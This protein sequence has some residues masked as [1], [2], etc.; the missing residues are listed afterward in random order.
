[1]TASPANPPAL[2]FSPLERAF[3]RLFIV[4]AAVSWVGMVLSEAG[5][6]TLGR[7]LAGAGLATVAAWKL[8]ASEWRAEPASREPAARGSHLWLGV[9]LA[10][11]AVLYW[12]PGEYLIEGADAS[13]YLAVGH[14]IHRTGAIASADPVLQML[15][16]GGRDALLERERTWPHPLNRFPGGMRVAGGENVVA[17]DFFHLL[18]VWIAISIGIVG[19]YG[20]YY[21]NPVF[22]V[23]AVL[24][25]W[26]I[27]RRAWSAG[28]GSVAA[29]L[30]AV[31]FGQVCAARTA[32]SEMLAQWLL[33]SGVLFTILAR[34]RR[35][36]VAAACAGAAIGLAGF[37]R[38]DALFLLLPLG[39]AWL[40]MVRRRRL[41]GPAWLWY[42]AT[43]GAV[44]ANA[45]AHAFTVSRLYT[46]RLSA[47]AWDAA[48]HA[49]TALGPGTALAILG[50]VIA[51]MIVC[52][53]LLPTR[54]RILALSGLMI[55]APAAL[56]P[57]VVSTAT[58]LLTPVGVAAVMAG[59]FLILRRDTDAR[60]LPLLV[61]F[62]AEVILWLV[63]REKTSWPA[64]FR[65]FVPAV[66]P[67]GLLLVGGL[68][69]HAG[70]AGPW[71]RR[72]TWLVPTGLAMTW[73]AQ[74]SPVLLA[75]PMRGVHAQVGRVADH[76]PAGAIVLSDRSVPSHLPLALQ[77]A[78][79]RE[80][81]QLSERLPPRGALREY[82]GRVLAAGRPAYLALAYFSHDASRHLWRSDLEGL[83]IRPAGVV[84]LRY[85]V[86]VSSETVFPRTLRTV[87]TNVELY[88][89]TRAAA[90][91]T[92]ALPLVLDLGE[93]DFAFALRGFYWSEAMG[94]ARARWTN[95]D[96]RILVPRL[97][98]PEG[99]DVTLLLRLA[100][101][102]PAGIAPPTIRVA[103]D[104][105][106][107]G[108][109]AASGPDFSVYRI[110]V[111]A[112]AVARLRAGESALTIRTGT[113]VPKA[114]GLG[115]D[116]R[117]LGI[118]LDWIRF[119]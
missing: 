12:Q 65:R 35:S 40:A 39:I 84:P 88:E 53:R 82:L 64:D 80:G 73:L 85:T 26:L 47:T 118:A 94:S 90:A 31:N 70:R 111:N 28:A 114:V 93:G 57:G 102:R 103:L 48:A 17:P 50:G 18:P 91:H 9:A 113:F 2:P 106:E 1:M 5:V 59:F 10:A 77:S 112:S 66:L 3:T 22:G 75:S 49:F 25:I 32:S 36:R 79:G 46:L 42:A 97:T 33:L 44:G 95:G 38:I 83:S 19:P 55:L 81:L 74:A 29:L 119:E 63:W 16:A 61:A 105:A 37:T 107:I 96:A 8:A 87:E 86:L 109:I 41:L 20:A 101:F 34:D 30:L 115:D 14:S 104:D 78:F 99:Q 92:A 62:A 24:T 4:I 110:T 52:A 89:I 68:V 6:F 56:S 23:L 76:I 116:A 108:A 58:L 67:L 71:V 43:L 21:A 27:G 117:A 15:P 98:V 72:V 69:E 45:V 13:V 100:T 7:V 11:A 54:A 51:G 60:L